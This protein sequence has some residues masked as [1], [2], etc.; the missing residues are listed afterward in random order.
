M[1]DDYYYALTE[2]EFTAALKRLERF[3]REWKARAER[4]EAELAKHQWQP[5]ETVPR[6]GIL[7]LLFG[8]RK[9]F[10]GTIHRNDY[11]TCGHYAGKSWVP[12][13]DYHDEFIASHW[14]PLPP[15]PKEA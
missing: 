4:A 15:P 10:Y 9:Q 1:S 8:C 2:Y 14:M 7:V 12:N 11:V 13:G 3:A 6:D 5:I